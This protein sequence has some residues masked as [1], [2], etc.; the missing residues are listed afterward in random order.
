[1]APLL[2]LLALPS[3]PPREL[4]LLLLWILLLLLAMVASGSLSLGQQEHNSTR[5][6]FGLAA[7]LYY[8]LYCASLALTSVERLYDN[9]DN[10]VNFF[11]PFTFLV[12]TP[13][14]E[15]L[16]FTQALAEPDAIDFLRAADHEVRE[17]EARGHWL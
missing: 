12:S 8:P 17:H 13:N 15:S 6:F 10:T 3:P 5:R 1:M 14:S 2:L 7:F 11:H 16:T 4:I 9:L